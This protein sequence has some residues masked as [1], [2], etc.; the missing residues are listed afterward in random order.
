MFSI[1]K[2][3]TLDFK[4]KYTYYIQTLF[5][6]H[7]KILMQTARLESVCAV[8]AY[9]E[10][11]ISPEVPLRE[12]KGWFSTKLVRNRFRFLPTIVTIMYYILM[13][14]TYIM[15][16]SF[17]IISI[18]YDITSHRLYTVFYVCWICVCKMS[19]WPVLCVFGRNCWK[20]HTLSIHYHILCL[21]YTLCMFGYIVRYIS[22]I[23]LVFDYSQ[24]PHIIYMY[25][26]IHIYII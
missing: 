19:E 4:Q 6:V 5:C 1:V 24:R 18:R 22:D 3:F 17:W 16:F 23:Y 21:F 20:P 15:F 25:I 13:H 8:V 11:Q 14:G 12:N 2:S 10:K 26:Y 9:L 7:T